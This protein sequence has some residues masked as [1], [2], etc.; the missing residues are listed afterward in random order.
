MIIYKYILIF[1]IYLFYNIL[2]RIFFRI[3]FSIYVKD[4]IIFYVRMTRVCSVFLRPHAWALSW[5]VSSPEV[6]AYSSIRPSL[7]S[8]SPSARDL[9][10][11]SNL[12]SVRYANETAVASDACLTGSRRRVRYSS[13]LDGLPCWRGTS[14]LR[15]AIPPSA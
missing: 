13:S 1:S 7:I 5:G 14:I 2:F 3:Y 12:A 8:S 15:G 4:S 10:S 11:P 6:S 9:I